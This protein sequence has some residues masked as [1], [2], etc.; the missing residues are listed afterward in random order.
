MRERGVIFSVIYLKCIHPRYFYLKCIL[1]NA[2]RQDNMRER[3]VILSAIYLK[4][5]HPRHCFYLKCI[6][7]NATRQDKTHF[8]ER[9]MGTQ[10]GGL[11]TT[12][13]Y[14][15][16][17][18]ASYRF[19][20]SFSS[21]ACQGAMVRSPVEGGP[22][23][24]CKCKQSSLWYGR[25]DGPKYCKKRA[26]MRAGGYLRTQ[27]RTRPPPAPHGDLPPDDDSG[28]AGSSALPDGLWVSEV[29]SCYGIRCGA[30]R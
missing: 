22:C 6:L 18:P 29:Y 8:W 16:V 19:Y 21:S 30:P 5:T 24:M 26:C 28:D 2:T 17:S 3:G 23:T 25:R 7:G 27:P 15:P 1:G 13:S 10:G 12:A 14:P 9:L 20:L 4:C 11:R